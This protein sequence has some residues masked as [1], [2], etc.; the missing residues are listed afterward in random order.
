MALA[1]DDRS[2][3]T[4]STLMKDSAKR[5]VPG[6]AAPRLRTKALLSSKIIVTL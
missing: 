5:Y 4:A 3:P 1:T 6:Q 2:M